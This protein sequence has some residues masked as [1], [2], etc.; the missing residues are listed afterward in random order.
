MEYKT[1]QDLYNYFTHEI[2]RI[3]EQQIEALRKEMDEKKH[4]ELK[5][6]N[7]QIEQKMRKYLDRELKSLNTDFSSEINRIHN[8]NHRKLMDKRKG[9][10]QEVFK[11]AEDKLKTFVQSDDYRP[12]MVNRI[13]KAI[14]FLDA[15]D[16]VFTVKEDDK[17]VHDVLKH[18]FD[19]AYTI[20][21]DSSIRFGG[22]KAKSVEKGLETDETFTRKLEEQKEWFY[23]NSNLFIRH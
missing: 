6:I 23:A 9:L 12:L 17:V 1:D 15:K 19:D 21:T 22:F 8:E 4:R 2:E 11:E 5:R 18:D 14:D 3:G 13:Q 7:D 10:L 20:E 16:I